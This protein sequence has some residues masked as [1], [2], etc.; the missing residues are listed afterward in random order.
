[1][2]KH[3]PYRPPVENSGAQLN[4]KAN[5]PT[6]RLQLAVRISIAILVLPMG[7]LIFLVALSLAAYMRGDSPAIW[8][9]P[10]IWQFEFKA[11]L[12]VAVTTSSIGSALL[13]LGAICGYLDGIRKPNLNSS[14]SDT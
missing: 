1:M 2:D 5:R 14:E 7:P 13:L 9:D 4:S 11:K 8:N 3:G 10:E 6:H 12:G